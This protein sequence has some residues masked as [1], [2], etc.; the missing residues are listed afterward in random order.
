MMART[1]K[2]FSVD[3][4]ALARK[5]RELPVEKPRED[6]HLKRL[7]EVVRGAAVPLPLPL[8]TEGPGPGVEETRS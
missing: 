1:D 8:L 2:A 6:D 7:A 3:I 4:P 5:I